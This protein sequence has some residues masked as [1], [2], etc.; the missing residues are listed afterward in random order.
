MDDN[1]REFFIFL[2]SSMENEIYINFTY[3]QDFSFV[4]DFVLIYLTNVNGVFK[5]VVKFDCSQKELIHAHYFFKKYS[6]KD[7]LELLPT[8]DTLF[9]LK[10][11]LVKDWQ[12]YLVKFNEG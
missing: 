12:K 4:I 6:W 11:N 5:E 8:V 10:G 3:S 9:S 7:N 2:D 1:F